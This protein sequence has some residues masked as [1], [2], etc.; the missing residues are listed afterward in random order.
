MALDGRGSAPPGVEAL[1]IPHSGNL[2][3]ALRWNAYGGGPV[4]LEQ[5]QQRR[6]H[7]PLAEIYQLKGSSAAH[8]LLSP[9]DEWADFSIRRHFRDDR[10]QGVGA[11]WRR[12]LAQGMAFE[13]RLGVNPHQLGAVGGS[14]SHYAAGTYDE[15]DVNFDRSPQGRGSVFPKDLGGWEGFQTPV[16]ASHGSG[17]LTGVWAE[18]EHAGGAVCGHAPPGDLRHLGAAHQAA[19]VRRLWIG[20]PAGRRG[21]SGGGGPSPRRAD[22]AGAAPGRSRPGRCAELLRM[23]RAGPGSGRLQR[24]Q[25]VKGEL[26]SAGS[27]WLYRAAHAAPER[28]RS[29]APVR[30]YLESAGAQVRERVFDLAC[31]DGGPAGPGD[32]PLPRQRRDG[33]LG[34]LL[35]FRGQGRVRPAGAVDGPGL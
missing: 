23:G 18:G 16:K 15:R 5:A 17:G 1:A 7:E 26:E 3:N 13:E 25:V 4:T 2:V 29:L 35:R 32:P 14:D 22:G 20:R 19:P 24:L 11:Y 34:G 8:P 21:R 31:S 27:E 10:P 6:R 33:Q 12:L 30:E 9:N 28:V